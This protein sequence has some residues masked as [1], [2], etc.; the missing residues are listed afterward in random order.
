MTSSR[1]ISRGRS[2]SSHLLVILVLG[3]VAATSS[4]CSQAEVSSRRPGAAPA[5]TSAGTP[6]STVRASVVATSLSTDF[7]DGTTTAFSSTSNVSLSGA[8]AR[9]GPYG[10]RA[11][12]T[13]TRGGYLAWSS[14]RFRYGVRYGRITAWVKVVSHRTGE[15]VD[16]LSL[17]NARGSRNFDFYRDPGTGRWRYDLYRFDSELSTMTAVVGRWYLIEALV[18]FGGRGGTAY[19]ADLRINGI[20]QPSIESTGQVG[21]TV[22]SAWFGDPNPDHKHNVR[23]YDSLA[24][25]TDATPF[26]FTH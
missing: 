12:N 2:W 24:V 22:K 7:D 5:T 15:S 11:V 6:A 19:T 1:A 26:A 21:T 8:F 25:D 9:S 13:A 18:D 14:S 4:A 17:K 10:A 23:Y 20:P 16:V 3:L